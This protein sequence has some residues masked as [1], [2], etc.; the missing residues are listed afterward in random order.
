MGTIVEDVLE[1]IKNTI[2]ANISINKEIEMN[3][4]PVFEMP[5]D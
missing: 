2:P 4:P 3:L 5:G 1:L